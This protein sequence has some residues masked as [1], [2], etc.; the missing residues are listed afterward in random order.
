[1]IENQIYFRNL[2]TSFARPYSYEVK[3]KQ[4]EIWFCYFTTEKLL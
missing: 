2:R 1:M 3:L 4:S